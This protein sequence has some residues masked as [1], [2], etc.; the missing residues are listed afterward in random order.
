[1]V[2]TISRYMQRCVG[3]DDNGTLEYL[4]ALPDFIGEPNATCRKWST[5]APIPSHHIAEQN[6]GCCR[7][8]GSANFAHLSP[9]GR[10]AICRLLLAVKGKHLYG[11][12]PV[13]LPLQ[14]RRPI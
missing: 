14:E 10:Q 11:R 8:F 7:C 13:K 5:D 3:I 9:M 4:D 12:F 1:M 6:F 2:F